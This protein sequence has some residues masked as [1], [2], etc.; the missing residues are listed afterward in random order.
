MCWHIL[1]GEGSLPGLQMAAFSLCPHVASF[2]KRVPLIMTSF[3]LHDS[4][5]APFSNSHTGELG[6]PHGNLWGKPF[7]P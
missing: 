2:Q 6:L 5:K 3:N 7:C 1:S 4:V